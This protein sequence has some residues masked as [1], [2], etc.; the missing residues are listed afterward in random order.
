MGALIA[1]SQLPLRAEDK[2][3]VFPKRGRKE[4]LSLSYAVVNIGLAEPFSVLHLSDSH[5]TAIRPD[6]TDKLAVQE[7]PVRRDL[8]LDGRYPVIQGLGP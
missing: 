5:L 4:R 8:S 1:T 2:P 7:R 6:E 3:Q